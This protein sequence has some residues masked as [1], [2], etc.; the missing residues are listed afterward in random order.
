MSE[1]HDICTVTA[2]QFSDWYDGVMSPGESQRLNQH[3][4]TCPQC[5][6]RLDEYDQIQ[7]VIRAHHTRVSQE[8]VWRG[9]RERVLQRPVRS[10]YHIPWQPAAAL[11]AVVVLVVALAQILR[12]HATPSINPP[13]TVSDAQAWGNYRHFSYDLSRTGDS[14]FIPSS[15]TSDGL[16]LGGYTIAPDGQSATFDILILA[17]MKMQPI[18]SYSITRPDEALSMQ[19]GINYALVSNEDGS[20]FKSYNLTTGVLVDHS[21]DHAM[22]LDAALDGSIDTQGIILELVGTSIGHNTLQILHLD[23]EAHLPIASD[24]TAT[25][26][27]FGDYLVYQQSNGRIGMIYHLITQQYSAVPSQVT[28]ALFAPEASF[29]TADT[30]AFFTQPV[31]A[32]HTVELGE[33]DDLDSTSASTHLITTTL[34]ADTHV[35]AA[36]DRLVLL[37]H[38]RQY[39]AWDRAQR[40]FVTLPAGYQAAKLSGN[41]LWLAASNQVMVINTNSLPQQ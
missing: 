25:A 22:V 26:H 27:L 34:A 40:R 13:L 2:G 15:L 4:A 9:V 11:L 19:L 16:L 5:R 35:V 24:V 32:S 8:R 41:W 21:Q 28:R 6:R 38:Q 12:S 31:D 20:F 7:L 14:R 29:Q 39:I 18:A 30:T 23:N 3:V 33:V 37:S 17:T 10:G 36:N 1:G